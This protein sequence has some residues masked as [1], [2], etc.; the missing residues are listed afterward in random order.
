MSNR[1]G[2]DIEGIEDCNGGVER[3]QGKRRPGPV[4][5]GISERDVPGTSVFEH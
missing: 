2:C 1:P 3:I 4:N 5:F